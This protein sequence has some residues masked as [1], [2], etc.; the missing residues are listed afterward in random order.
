[1]EEAELRQ[2]ICDVARW[3]FD[4][5]HNAPG[6]GNVTARV[7]DSL[8]L[9]TPTASHKGRLRPA[10][11][12]LVD[13]ASGRPVDGQRASTE[14][15]LHRAVYEVRPD[16]RAIVHAHSPHAVAL[17]VAGLSLEHPVVPEAIQTLGA[18]PTVPY[19]GPASHEVAEASAPFALCGEAFILERHGPVTLGRSLD[20][21]YARLEVLEHTAKITLLAHMAG[22][23]S[24][25]APEEA[26]R[27]R[28]QALE[29]GM[30][31]RPR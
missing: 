27:L 5:G 17:T 10:Q 15:R 28:A 1:M 22:S 29:A 14:L 18:V 9:T 4:R 19:R 24:P 3:L 8:L 31:S 16:V 2:L 25:I 7:G 11:I 6:D 23:A 20:E 12:V 26:A 30:I 21:A 13:F